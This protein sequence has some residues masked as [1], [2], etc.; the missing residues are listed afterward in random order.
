MVDDEPKPGGPDDGL[1]DSNSAGPRAAELTAWLRTAVDHHQ[2]GE[3]AQAQE[4]YEQI[5]ARE[6]THADAL[7]YFG[8]LCQQRGDSGQA[9]HL[10]RQ[11][12]A[13]RPDV[14]PYHDNLGTVL[15]QTGQ[16]DAAL[17]AYR[18]AE[19]LEPGIVERAGN[20]GLV[21]QRLGRHSQAERHYRACI[22]RH[23]HDMDSRLALADLLSKGD[24][25]R[26]AIQA[27]REIL[28]I[29]EN[30]ASARISLGNVL[31]DD[32]QFDA[33][34]DEYR[35]VIARYPENAE[36]W[37]NQGRALANVEQFG[38]AQRSFE[39]ALRFDPELVEAK[40]GLARM[41]ERL[42]LFDR[43]Y[44][45]FRALC[46]TGTTGTTG[47]EADE[48]VAS[49]S[50]AGLLRIIRVLPMFEHDPL[51]VQIMLSAID[52]EDTVAS[53]CMYALGSQLAAKAGL[54][55]G[56]CVDD[57][58]ALRRAVA[59]QLDPL[60]VVAVEQC[61]NVVPAVERWLCA[62]RRAMLHA[63]RGDLVGR[64]PLLRALAMQ[65][66]ANEYVFAVSDD[67]VGVIDAVLAQ[68]GPQTASGLLASGDTVRDLLLYA[69]YGP[70]SELWGAESLAALD[71]ETL[72]PWLAPIVLHTVVEPHREWEM[73]AEIEELAPIA[74]SSSRLVR[75]QYEEH[76]YPR[77]RELPPVLPLANSFSIN[78]V[79]DAVAAD[80]Q[81]PFLVAGCGTG[82]EPLLLATQF[83]ERAI[84]A[85]DLS[86]ASLGYASRMAA[87]L[88]VENVRFVHGDLFDVGHLGCRFSMI[89][90]S[91]VLHHLA[92]PLAGW[93]VLTEHL[94]DSGV[95]KVALYSRRARATINTARERVAALGLSA[96]T[97]GVRT[98][99]ARVLAGME[100]T[101]SSLLD[102]E[103]FYTTSMCR[104]L[105]FHPLEHQ[106]D[107]R[108][109]ATML[110]TLGLQFE[111]FELPHPL[112]K[113]Q[114]RAARLGDETDLAAWGQ[115]EER[116]PRTFDGMYVMWCR[117]VHL[118]NA[119][120]RG[121]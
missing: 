51:L 15:E 99:R 63:N 116:N 54:T 100:P 60:F 39:R 115:F 114:F 47:S 29:N 18:E 74:D 107:L 118:T 89:A 111:G 102:S 55:Q 95:M 46:T 22:E 70:L 61:V 120:Q 105:I 93:R 65:S 21:L 23:P 11:A 17:S 32:G 27:Y 92:D 33:A 85:L 43:A 69:C 109:I 62:V 58:D 37:H 82:F 36:A 53:H 44:A 41:L 87:Q 68:L 38:E 84:V 14:A 25:P 86:R 76:P 48:D 121:E 4:L 56:D 77:W 19:R 80:R 66:F 16:F 88:G 78:S 72:G 52:S 6:P 71:A 119:G 113:Q 75:A 94:R 112:L 42:G 98:L 101:L 104:D 12:I 31:Q 73:A 83:P 79:A 28:D 1:D 64:E 34:L 117:K 103:D 49:R 24:N 9:E 50:R 57:A 26:A 2:A 8:I 30:H 108:E 45:A 91:G 35:R 110:D 67:E 3:L 20:V 81:A 96:D 7:Q 97:Q 10:I 13:V 59:L 5:L 106:F 40:L 90:A